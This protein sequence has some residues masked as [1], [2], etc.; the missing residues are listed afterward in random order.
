MSDSL[1]KMST[2][3]FKIQKEYRKMDMNIQMEDWKS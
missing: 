3:C 1:E 2:G